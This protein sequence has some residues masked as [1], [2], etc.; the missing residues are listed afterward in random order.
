MFG[1]F[2]QDLR[3]CTAHIGIGSLG[4]FVIFV[5]LAVYIIVAQH[6]LLQDAAAGKLLI[7]C[8]QDFFLLAGTGFFLLSIRLRLGFF[9]FQLFLAYFFDVRNAIAADFTVFRLFFCFF[10]RLSLFLSCRSRI[11]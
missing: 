3:H 4:Q 6:G 1:T 8:F 7:L 9:L 5:F 2:N 11:G 10:F